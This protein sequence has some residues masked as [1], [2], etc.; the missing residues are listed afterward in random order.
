MPVSGLSPF[1]ALR[2][3]TSGSQPRLLGEAAAVG[4]LRLGARPGGLALVVA[5]VTVRAGA[6]GI[7]VRALWQGGHHHF[8]HRPASGQV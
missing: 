3:E 5:E 1:S 8:L 7:A 6:V 2:G 4:V